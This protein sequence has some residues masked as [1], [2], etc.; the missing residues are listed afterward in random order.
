MERQTN[1]TLALLRSSHPRVLVIN[2]VDASM[3]RAE[4]RGSSAGRTG[5]QDTDCLHFMLPGVPDLWTVALMAALGRLEEM[6][7]GSV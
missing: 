2:A 6:V 3:L 7:A 4:M 5:G 1:L